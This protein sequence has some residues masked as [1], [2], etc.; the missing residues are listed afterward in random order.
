MWCKYRTVSKN[1]FRK[2]SIY[3]LSVDY[4]GTLKEGAFLL[5]LVPFVKK[6]CHNKAENIAFWI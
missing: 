4:R 5:K 2:M 1:D 6:K 3:K